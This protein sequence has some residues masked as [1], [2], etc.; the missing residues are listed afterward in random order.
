MLP[1]EKIPTLVDKNGNFFLR[2]KNLP[3]DLNPI[4]IIAEWK[5]QIKRLQDWGINPAYLDTHHHVHMMSMILPVFAKLGLETKL[6]LRSGDISITKKLRYI[7]ASCPDQTITSFH[8]E[9][10]DWSKLMKLLEEALE[11]HGQD[12]VIEVVCHPGFSSQELEQMSYYQVEREKELQVLTEKNGR[13]KIEDLGFSLVGM[14][15]V[16]RLR[17]IKNNKNIQI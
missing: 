6:P 9:N 14:N 15:E 8:K 1:P 2:S 5:A 17:P 16:S 11:E 4:E 10:C 3:F 13:K 7:G 12:A